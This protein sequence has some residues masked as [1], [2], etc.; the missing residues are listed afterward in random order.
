MY[1]FAFVTCTVSKLLF[2][3]FQREQDVSFLDEMSESSREDLIKVACD[4]LGDGKSEEMVIDT[5][6]KKYKKI[7][8][9]QIS[10][11]CRFLTVT[12]LTFSFCFF[13]TTETRLNKVFEIFCWTV[14]E[15]LGIGKLIFLFFFFLRIFLP[16]H[17]LYLFINFVL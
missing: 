13:F 1:T 11:L 16:V 10:I 4:L 12:F 14:I 8:R 6:R 17:K 2:F 9:P 7:L 15:Y 5:V 3:F